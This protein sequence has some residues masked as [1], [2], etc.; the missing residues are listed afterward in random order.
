MREF[1][2]AYYKPYHDAGELLD[3]WEEDF[4]NAENVNNAYYSLLNFRRKAVP[5]F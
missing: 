5:K 4:P 1:D 2:D 3:E